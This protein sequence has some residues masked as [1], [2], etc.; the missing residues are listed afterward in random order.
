MKKIVLCLA[1]ICWTLSAQ[2]Q[3][4]GVFGGVNSTI[5]EASGVDFDRD[6]GLELGVTVVH[7]YQTSWGLR[8]GAGFVGKN[9]SRGSTELGLSY[10]EIPATLLFRASPKVQLFGGL[11]LNLNLSDHCEVD[12]AA[13]SWNAESLVVNLPLGAR[14]GLEGPHF[15]EPI[16]EFGI[17]DVAN[18]TQIGNSLS[19]RYIYLFR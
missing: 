11:N 18:T 14:I 5:Y 6:F 2:A 8:T 10:L 19:V 17:T 16:V 4:W 3:T 7:M 13:C 15:I 9:S 12:G 1:T